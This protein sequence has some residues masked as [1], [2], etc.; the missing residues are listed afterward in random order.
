MRS[1]ADPTSGYASTMRRG[2][3]ARQRKLLLLR[4]RPRHQLQHVLLR[5]LRPVVE[6]HIDLATN[7]RLGNR[8]D[9]LPID[10]SKLGL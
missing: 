1:L 6:L 5:R 10:A 7:H 9:E 3:Y 4:Q 8:K 2:K